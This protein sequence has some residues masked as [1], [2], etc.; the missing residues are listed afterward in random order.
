MWTLESYSTQG[1][2]AKWIIPARAP[3]QS[4]TA[5]TASGD[6]AECTNIQG[7]PV[8]SPCDRSPAFSSNSLKVIQLFL[9]TCLSWEKYI[10]QVTTNLSHSSTVE[11]Y[12]RQT[13]VKGSSY[14]NGKNIHHS[15]QQEDKK[16]ILHWGNRAV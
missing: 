7:T 5:Q 10:S 9:S 15:S 8:Q 12:L 3:F 2:T 1:F 6:Q 4:V 16:Q 13:S 14:H 11:S